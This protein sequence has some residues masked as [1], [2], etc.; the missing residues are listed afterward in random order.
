[1]IL[2]ASG[3]GGITESDA[4]L[5]LSS[6]AIMLGFN[7]RADAAARRVVEEKGLDLRY[8][9]IIYELIDDVK[10]ALSGLLKPI[11]TEE[12]IGWRRCAMS[13]VR[14]SSAP[15]PAAWWWTG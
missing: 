4:N 12:I 7:V 10:K 6:N 5:A 9:S 14:P 2:V 3:V 1:M 13:S 15:S 8:Y 11:I